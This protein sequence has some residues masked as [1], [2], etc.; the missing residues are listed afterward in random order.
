MARTLLV[1]ALIAGAAYLVYQKVGRAPSE[2]VQLVE[3]LNDRYV[4]LVG[5]FTS[6]AGRAGTFGLDSSFDIDAVVT[7]ILKIRRELAALRSTLTEDRAV[8]KADELAEKIEF[9]CRKN[10]I[11]RP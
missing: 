3:H 11:K 5:K 8:A 2:E 9:F 6:A 10:D 1:F 7:E 4:I